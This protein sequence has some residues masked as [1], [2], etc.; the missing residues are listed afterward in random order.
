MLDDPP[1]DQ[2]VDDVMVARRLATQ[3]TESLNRLVDA[4][5]ADPAYFHPVMSENPDY[6]VVRRVGLWPD[7]S[8]GAFYW[9]LEYHE[10]N[11]APTEDEFGGS[12]IHC[13]P[14]PTNML[15]R[16]AFTDM[17]EKRWRKECPSIDLTRPLFD[18]PRVGGI[19]E[20]YVVSN[21]VTPVLAEVAKRL[22]LLKTSRQTNQTGF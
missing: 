12:I 21:D 9:F 6:E 1:I 2:V 4:C 5:N 8:A 7:F 18:T 11:E 15:A 3:I 14:E 22:E 16:L 10:G 20:G 17:V 13:Y 19:N